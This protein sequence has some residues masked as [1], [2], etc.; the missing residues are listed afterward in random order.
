LKKWWRCDTIDMAE[1]LLGSR[2]R[3][4]IGSEI[5]SL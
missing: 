4:R 3:F 5:L 2:V 1:L